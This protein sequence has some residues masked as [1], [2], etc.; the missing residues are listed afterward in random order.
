M[1]LH[2]IKSVYLANT[3]IEVTIKTRINGDNWRGQ[4]I[5]DGFYIIS[6]ANDL[7]LY[8]KDNYLFDIEKLRGK[9]KYELKFRERLDGKKNQPAER[10]K[11]GE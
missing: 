10:V 1:E 3:K 4:L 9:D 7:M 11:N 5:E 2:K 6:N 8:K